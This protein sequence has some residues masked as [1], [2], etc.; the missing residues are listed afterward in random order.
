M[1]SRSVLRR[2]TEV[3]ESQWGLVTSAQAVARGLGYVA[4]ARLAEAGDLVRL[5]H[6]VYKEAGAP[7]DE[8]LD[9]R[10]A[11]LAAEPAAEA[12]VRLQVKPGSAVV[13][14]ESAAVLHGIGNLRA[15]KH[16]FTTPTR[17]QTQRVDVRYRTRSLA[18]TDVTVKHGLPVTT[19]ERTISDL[20]EAD[21]QLEHVGKVLSDATERTQLDRNHLV[22][23]LSPLALRY[24]FARGD[25]ESL[26]SRIQETSVPLA[27]ALVA[28]LAQS[29][30]IVSPER[31]AHLPP[32]TRDRV[33]SLSIE[34][35]EQLQE[36]HLQQ[37]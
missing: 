12:W 32:V 8:F 36:L 7:S 37:T 16:E 30:M 22:D 17:R 3:T 26:L 33:R 13:S 19:I 6:G 1:T 25:G 14:G 29:L 34:L 4:L 27:E 20:V 31:L 10:A 18:P 2:V 35:V 23:L 5:A 15:M 24:G 11:W 9:L 28:R 21:T